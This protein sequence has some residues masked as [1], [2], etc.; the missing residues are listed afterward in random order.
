MKMKEFKQTGIQKIILILTK[1]EENTVL[2]NEQIK[3][4]SSEE[5]RGLCYKIWTVRY[6]NTER[7]EKRIWLLT[8]LSNLE[9]GSQSWEAWYP[10]RHSFTVC[11]NH[12][13]TAQKLKSV[14]NLHRTLSTKG[15]KNKQLSLW[16]KW[17]L[18][19]TTEFKYWYMFLVHTFLILLK[20][21][22]K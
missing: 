1:Q 9:N 13:S 2:I 17:S 14:W 20:L 16:P 21:P 7:R 8:T 12:C 11:V 10:L 18:R 19:N 3:P 6:G 4:Y 22:Y 15:G 5:P